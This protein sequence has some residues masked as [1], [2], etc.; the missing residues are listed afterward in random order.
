MSGPLANE[1]E[2][3]VLYWRQMERTHPQGAFRSSHFTF[4]VL[5]ASL[6]F[7]WCGG[8]FG[9]S[10]EVLAFVRLQAFSFAMGQLLAAEAY[11]VPAVR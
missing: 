8:L 10:L 4:P 2:M 5:C 3:N 6:V 9:V 1:N 11:A 7:P